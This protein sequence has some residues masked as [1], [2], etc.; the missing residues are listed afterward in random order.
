MVCLP[1]PSQSGRTEPRYAP[2]STASHLRYEL[3]FPMIPQRLEYPTGRL[4]EEL[5]PQ[6]IEDFLLCPADLSRDLD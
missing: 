6:P 5:D 1:E 2:R 4:D 3:G